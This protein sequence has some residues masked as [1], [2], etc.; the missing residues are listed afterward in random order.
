MNC[1]HCGNQVE[2]EGILARTEVC[3]N[4]DED[5]HCCLNCENYD[6]SAHNRCREPQSEWVSDREKANFCDYFIARIVTPAGAKK[7]PADEA[8]K[9]F[10]NLFKN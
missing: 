2:I 6:P 9:A 1:H 10:D 7:A 5:L 4:C 3:P 8:K